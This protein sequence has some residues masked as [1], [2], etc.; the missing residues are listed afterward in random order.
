MKVTNKKI[1]SILTKTLQLHKKDWVARLPK[2]VWEYRTTWKKITSFTPYELVYGKI[3]I[4]S[5]VFEYN[6]LRTSVELDMALIVA[7]KERLHHLNGL[8]EIRMEAIHHIEIVQKKRTKW[9]DQYVKTKS[10]NVGD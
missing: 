5:I 8:D 2:V 3:T 6:T 1:E 7:Q 4:L 9:H 10:F